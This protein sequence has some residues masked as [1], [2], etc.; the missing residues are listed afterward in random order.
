MDLTGLL[1]KLGGF[2]NAIRISPEDHDSSVYALPIP[3]TGIEGPKYYL[4]PCVFHTTSIRH[5]SNPFAF[6]K[7][8]QGGVAIRLSFG[9]V[10]TWYLDPLVDR[11]FRGTFSPRS[12]SS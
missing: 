2:D 11:S 10:V 9:P 7:G 4:A 3:E 6:R 12:P 1:Q 5:N 8:N